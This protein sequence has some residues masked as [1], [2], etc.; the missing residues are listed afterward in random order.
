MAGSWEISDIRR[1]RVLVVTI[2]APDWPVTLTWAE[3]LRALQLPAFSQIIKV[4][5]MPYGV[6]RNQALKAALDGGFAWLFFLDADVHMPADGLLKLLESG[7]DYIAGVYRQRFPPWK[8]ASFMKTMVPVP[9]QPGQVMMEKGDLP[10]HAP[11]AIIPVDFL[12]TGATLISRRCMETVLARY[13]KPFEWT[14]DIDKPGGLSEDYTF[15]QN[16][17][18]VGFQAWLHTAIECRHEIKLAI[19]PNGP[20]ML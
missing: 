17:A 9:N 6:A 8:I 7:R 16:A 14:L 5:G 10:P 20:E 15:T 3:S 2:A 13:P 4:T 11:G 19:G 18:S 1:N 12:H